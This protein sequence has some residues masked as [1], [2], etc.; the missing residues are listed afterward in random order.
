[1]E[2]WLDPCAGTPILQYY[3][4]Q[5][6]SVYNSKFTLHSKWKLKKD[7]ASELVSMQVPPGKGF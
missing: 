5:Q 1:M 4:G 6:W 2:G 7:K 3:L